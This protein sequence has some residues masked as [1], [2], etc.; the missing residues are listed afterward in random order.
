MLSLDKPKWETND[1]PEV[2]VGHDRQQDDDDLI[3]SRGLG[4][5]YLIKLCKNGPMSLCYVFSFRLQLEY[6]ISII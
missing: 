3:S 2:I 5:L 4:Y 6:N 1:T